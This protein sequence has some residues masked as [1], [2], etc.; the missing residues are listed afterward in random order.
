MHAKHPRD[1]FITIYGRKPAIEAL[2]DHDLVIDKVVLARDA[3]GPI[4]EEILRHARQRQIP[5]R[6]V[7][8]KDVTKISR[9]GRQDQGIAVDVVAPRMEALEEFIAGMASKNAG[10]SIFSLLALDGITT[11]AN[12]GMLIRSQVA[13]GVNGIVLPRK[14]CPE[15]GPLIIKASAGV[16][17][18]SQIL[19]CE[20]IALG[21]KMLKDAGCTVYGLSGTADQTIFQAE[22]ARQSVFVLGN[23]TT[24]IAPENVAFIDQWLAIPMRNQ[25][26]SINVAC[27]ATIVCYELL[28]RCLR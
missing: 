18:K 25:V 28:R 3:K 11:P 5:V 17:F 10:D 2:T 4:I 16:A 1:T 24:G 22:F 14:G 6:R 23:E 26:E 21:L 7:S 12:L 8:Q 9:N 27:A 13:A 15:I 19:R 20:T